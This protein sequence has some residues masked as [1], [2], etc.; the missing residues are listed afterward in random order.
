MFWRETR[1]DLS[2]F[3]GED[4]SPIKLRYRVQRD[5]PA[6]NEWW[7]IDQIMLRVGNVVSS[8]F[9]NNPSSLNFDEK[10]THNPYLELY[11]QPFNSFLIVRVKGDF[12]GT[13]C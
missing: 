4:G 7:A 9:P 10:G 12:D 13:S 1:V 11:P 5:R 3:A 2:R 6:E 8:P